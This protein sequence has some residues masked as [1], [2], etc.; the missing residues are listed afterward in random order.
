MKDGEII[1]QGSHQELINN[2]DTYIDLYKDE[3]DNIHE[4]TLIKN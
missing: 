2:C 4:K 1:K 3:L